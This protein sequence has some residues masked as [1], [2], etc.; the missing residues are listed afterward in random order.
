MFKR[1]NV[2]FP[3]KRYQAL[4]HGKKMNIKDDEHQMTYSFRQPAQTILTLNRE[5]LEGPNETRPV[6]RRK[7]ALY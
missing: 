2:H 5:K 1:L 6:H 7:T 3:I 4:G